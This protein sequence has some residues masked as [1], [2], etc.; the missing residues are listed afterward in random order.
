MSWW[1][2][3]GRKFDKVPN[4]IDGTEF[5]RRWCVW[6]E[7]LYSRSKECPSALQIGGPNGFVVIML[8]LSW[9]GTSG[10]SAEWVQSVKAVT[11]ALV[12]LTK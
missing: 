10:A 4:V 8:L 2:K 7:M 6:W 3:R 1:Q 9:W 11:D 5:G 12:E